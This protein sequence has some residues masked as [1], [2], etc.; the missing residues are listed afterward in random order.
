MY[1]IVREFIKNQKFLN[2]KEVSSQFDISTLVVPQAL[3]LAV[4]Q[5]INVKYHAQ[6]SE[7]YIALYAN[8]LH[9]YSYRQVMG[10]PSFISAAVIKD[11]TK[12]QPREGRKFTLP[13]QVKVHHGEE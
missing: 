6:Y 4:Q 7:P 1:K 5:C 9:S 12:K 3:F 11:P 13:F 8:G 10:C 2:L